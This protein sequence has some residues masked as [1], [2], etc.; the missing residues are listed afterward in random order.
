MFNASRTEF[1]EIIM[2]TEGTLHLTVGTDEE[3]AL[4]LWFREP[5]KA[6]PAGGK[7]AVACVH[8]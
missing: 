3:P 1:G 6:V 8:E 7:P 4:G 2:G 5:A